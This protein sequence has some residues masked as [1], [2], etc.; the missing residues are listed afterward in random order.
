MEKA[1]E[2]SLCIHKNNWLRACRLFLDLPT[3]LAAVAA[4]H[5]PDIRR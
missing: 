4:L 3:L 2:I 5:L 1:L